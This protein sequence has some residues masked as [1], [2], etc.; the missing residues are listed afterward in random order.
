MPPLAPPRGRCNLWG[1]LTLA[2]GVLLHSAVL[3]AAPLRIGF[4]AAEG[5]L[6]AMG[7]QDRAAWDAA[8]G[9][10]EATL[11]LRQAN[12]SF[13][14]PSGVVRH[15]TDFDVVWRHQGDAIRRDGLYQG[16]SLAEI[17]RFAEGGG[18]LLLSGG[19]GHG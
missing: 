18:G 7:P 6:E 16:P 11:L 15:L 14:D 5:S 9:L 10:G 1:I 12:G 3:H 2:G 4:L 8:K 13:A 17:R 19:A